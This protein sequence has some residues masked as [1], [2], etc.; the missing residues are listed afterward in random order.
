[1]MTSKSYHRVKGFLV[2]S[3]AYHTQAGRLLTMHHSS[4][5]FVRNGKPCSRESYSPV[6]WP[7]GTLAF[8]FPGN[9]GLFWA[10]TP[11][12]SALA[13]IFEQGSLYATS[14]KWHPRPLLPSFGHFPEV[15][16]P[17]QASFEAFF[18]QPTTFNSFH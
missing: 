14:P 8:Y 10:V 9:F 15:I 18:T 6:S 11:F 17:S 13:A 12:A 2:A 5:T 4:S 7:V 3:Q 1:M 16:L